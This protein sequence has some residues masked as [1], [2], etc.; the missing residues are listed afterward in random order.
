MKKIFIV[1]TLLFFHADVFAFGGKGPIL[2]PGNGGRY[3]S[4][5]IAC[6]SINNRTG[7]HFVRKS[8]NQNI[9]ESTA[10]DSCLS[11]SNRARSCSNTRCEREGNFTQASVRDTYSG[12]YFS[13]NGYS[14]IEAR[15]NAM[16]R[17]LQSSRRGNNCRFVR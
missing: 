15:A 8:Y 17:C 13:G 2:V 6:V 4:E 11:S 7:R 1:C 9:A 3:R 10:L 5:S 14:R 12:Q 16:N